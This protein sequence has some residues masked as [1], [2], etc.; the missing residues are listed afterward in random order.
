MTNRGVKRSPSVLPYTFGVPVSG[1]EGFRRTVIESD[2]LCPDGTLQGGRVAL[3][4]K[5]S[6]NR[7][8]RSKGS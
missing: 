4:I 7:A 2:S 5:A 6:R 8:E 3:T 1:G